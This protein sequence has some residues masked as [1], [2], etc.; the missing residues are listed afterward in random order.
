M[1]V[2]GTI[3]KKMSK[4][5]LQGK[6]TSANPDA[7]ITCYEGDIVLAS[8]KN[9]YKL[10][11]KI[12]DKIDISKIKNPTLKSTSQQIAELKDVGKVNEIKDGETI[13]IKW[14]SDTIRLMIWDETM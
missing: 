7:S 11:T 6:F 12:A 13:N 10:F 5:T 14:K 8:T 9:V 4:E 1:N 2:K 3:I